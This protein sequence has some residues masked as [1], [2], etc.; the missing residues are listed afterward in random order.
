MKTNTSRNLLPTNQNTGFEILGSQSNRQ[1]QDYMLRMAKVS[2]SSIVLPE[3]EEVMCFL[4]K[5]CFMTVVV[6]VK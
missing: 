5:V 4:S 6:T 3:I 2:G 1:I